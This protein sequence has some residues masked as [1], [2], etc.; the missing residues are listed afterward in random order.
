MSEWHTYIVE[1]NDGSLY[2]GITTDIDR[3]VNEHNH[4]NKGA[5]YTKTKRPV[6]LVYSESHTDRSESSKREYFIKQL[7]R[8]DKLKL[9]ESNKK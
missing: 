8:S 5:K 3:R 4:S 7:K 1:C 2:T 9:I 6:R